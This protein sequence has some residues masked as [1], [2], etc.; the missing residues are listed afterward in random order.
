MW[1]MGYLLGDLARLGDVVDRITTVDLIGYAERGSVVLVM[2]NCAWT[3]Y[4]VAIE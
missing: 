2:T 4:S 3:L 1:Y